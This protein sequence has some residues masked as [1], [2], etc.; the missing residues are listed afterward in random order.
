MDGHIAAFCGTH[1][2]ELS[3]SLI[4]GLAQTNPLQQSLAATRLLAEVQRRTGPSQLP[5]LTGWLG[6]RLRPV[7]DTFHHRPYRD[8]LGA[9]LGRVVARGVVGELCALLDN[10]SVR[11][12]DE[13][14]FHQACLEF[15]AATTE[16][17]WLEQG[18]LTGPQN[19]RRGSREVASI[20]S[21]VSAGL[22]LVV[23]TLIHWI[24]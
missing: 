19:V 11:R 16:I 2:K 7:V 12:A 22:L 4:D 8:E 24:Y 9:D 1:L 18:G 20:I 5:A 21:S 13:Q 15:G 10:E 23:I 6:E 3:D 14:G 17:A